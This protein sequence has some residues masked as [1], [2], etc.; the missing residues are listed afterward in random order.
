[1]CTSCRLG[2]CEG[3]KGAL[4]PWNWSWEPPGRHCKPIPCPLQ[5]QVLRA[6]LNVFKL[7]N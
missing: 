1:M 7:V 5:E 3:Q 2:A 4:D 6:V